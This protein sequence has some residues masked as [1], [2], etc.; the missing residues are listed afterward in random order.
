MGHEFDN[1]KGDRGDREAWN[2]QSMG[3]Q[4]VRYILVTKQQQRSRLNVFRHKAHMYLLLSH[5]IYI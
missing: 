5:L 2:E 1:L 3:S 4:R